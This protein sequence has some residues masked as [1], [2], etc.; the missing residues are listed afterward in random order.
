MKFLHI[1]SR[2]ANDA[3]HLCIMLLAGGIASLHAFYTYPA[4]DVWWCIFGVIAV[5]IA[6]LL[7]IRLPH[8]KWGGVLASSIF[9]FLA[10]RQGIPISIRGCT[11]IL[12]ALLAVYWF[13][14][15]DYSNRFEDEGKEANQPDMATPNHPPD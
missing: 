14:K 12:A 15:I 1:P 11:T 2:D 6:P 5:V 13:W 3:D 10:I 9:V 4:F 7:W 8:A